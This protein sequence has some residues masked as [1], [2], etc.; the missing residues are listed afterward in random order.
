MNEPRRVRGARGTARY[1]YD[2]EGEA[3]RG[4]SDELPN[5]T[6]YERDDWGRNRDGE[7]AGNWRRDPWVRWG[8]TAK[9]VVP[10]I[11]IIPFNEVSFQEFLELKLPEPALL[12]I[13]L[14]A[15]SPQATIT[16]ALTVLWTLYIGVGAHM[17][18]RQYQNFVTLPFTPATLIGAPYAG[19]LVLSIPARVVRIEG[20]IHSTIGGGATV[21]VVAQAAP[22]FPQV[23]V[24]T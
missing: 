1:V 3:H 16:Q 19:D 17:Q 24:I 2:P 7:G 4:G 20:L 13:R 22:T 10:V 5:I 12:S 6:D 21:D 14:S 11:G 23:A 9:V 18:K 8:D 15:I